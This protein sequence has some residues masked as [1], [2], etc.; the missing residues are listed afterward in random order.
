MVTT[1]PYSGLRDAIYE[2]FCELEEDDE[3][4]EAEND[5]IANTAILY[6]NPSGFRDS[7]DR[8]LW[9]RSSVEGWEL[10]PPAYCIQVG[11]D[12]Y[13]DEAE[14]IGEELEDEFDHVDLEIYILD[15]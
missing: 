7:K 1:L 15:G 3:M 9:S 13:S 4:L 14:R 2:K 8:L 11:N 6:E 10:D 12:K 5:V